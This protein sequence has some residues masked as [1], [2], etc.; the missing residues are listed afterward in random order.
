MLG[1]IHRFD[2]RP[3]LPLAALI[4]YFFTINAN[5]LSKCA[6]SP[7]GAT[8]K[9]FYAVTPAK[10]EGLY[11]IAL[12]EKL[13]S[14]LHRNNGIRELFEVPDKAQQPCLPHALPCVIPPA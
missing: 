7:A 2:T 12:K 11:I 3:G 8:S 14:G 4:Q 10:V 13:D 5:R 6:A 1:V 9:T